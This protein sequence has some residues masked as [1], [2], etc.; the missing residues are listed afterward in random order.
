MIP[1]SKDF[2]LKI[3]RLAAAAIATGKVAGDHPF[4]TAGA[5][6]LRDAL[7]A[8]KQQTVTTDELK[9]AAGE[10]LSPEDVDAHFDAAYAELDQLEK[11]ARA[12][13]AS[14]ASG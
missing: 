13:L 8:V 6:V 12:S 2:L 4:V 10:Y 5:E 11:E 3:T 9:A 14:R 7:D 1:V